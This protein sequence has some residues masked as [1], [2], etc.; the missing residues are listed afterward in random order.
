[1]PIIHS[2]GLLLR[3]PSILPVAADR[4]DLFTGFI[5]A[6][7]GWGYPFSGGREPSSRPTDGTRLLAPA[8][9]QRLRTYGVL[10]ELRGWDGGHRGGYYF[11]T[12][13]LPR[14]AVASPSPT[15]SDS[16]ACGA[17]ATP[18]RAAGPSRW[19]GGHPSEGRRCRWRREGRRR[20]RS[21]H[22]CVDSTA[23][24]FPTAVPRWRRTVVSVGWRMSP[25]A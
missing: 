2:P 4:P 12:G 11:T 18:Y 16:S 6:A 10:R 1:M 23:E 8:H 25:W 17:W 20:W 19:A 21:V 14:T 7:P 15:S 13:R 24:S 5:A 9:W 22:A 3:H